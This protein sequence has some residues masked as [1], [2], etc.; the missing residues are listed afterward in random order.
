MVA[1][2][3]VLLFALTSVLAPS[4]AAAPYPIVV[5]DALARTV[6][7]RAKP[8]RIISVAPSVTEILFA[9]DLDRQIVGVS[10]ADDYPPNKVASKPKVGNVV[11][12]VERI[13][14]LRP[15]LILGVAS[16]QRGELERL[17]ALKQPVFAVDARTLGQLHEQILLIGNLTGREAA[18]AKLVADMRRKE[19]AVGRAIAGRG[20]PKVYVEIWGE[21][22]MTAGQGTFVTD[23]IRRAGGI[24]VFA[25]VQGW[26][27]VSEESVIRRNPEV[28]VV[29]YQ[30]GT[31][32]L[33]RRGWQQVSAVKNRR[34][35]V[36]SSSLV[37]RPG[38]RLV[39]GLEQLARIIH[40]EA[41]P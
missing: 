7:L 33:T 22:L 23:L 10:A 12:D 28:I 35:G 38:P 9:L 29:T 34:V 19:T 14:Q 18:A 15:D 31:R 4:V 25:D 26:P 11:L 39:I 36:I 6:T 40:P 27:Q 16:L 32:V 37:F 2:A 3:A 17:I 41:F 30:Q 1:M 5:R 13:L 21:P 8:Q 24:N 20:T